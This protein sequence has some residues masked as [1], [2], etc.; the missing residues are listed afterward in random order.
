MFCPNCGKNIP[1]GSSFCPDCGQPVGTDLGAGTG[2]STSG[3]RQGE[4]PGSS[5]LKTTRLV[6]NIVSMVLFVLILF[7]SCAAGVG[8]A[9]MNNDDSSGS[10]GAVLAFCMLIA[11]IVGIC[12]RNQSGNT[13]RYITGGLYAL[14]GLM[15]MCDVGIYKDLEIWAALS[16]AFAVC[17]F[18]PS[19]RKRV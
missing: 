9:L 4:T 17:F 3:N 10:L 19:R 11:G 18:W 8:N 5:G 7:Q 12:T 2:R 13:G 6:V 16:F 1:D 15:G 14:G